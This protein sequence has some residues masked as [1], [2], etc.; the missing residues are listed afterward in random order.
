MAA[1]LKDIRRGTATAGI[2]LGTYLFVLAADGINEGRAERDYASMTP[3]QLKNNITSS[4]PA[5][6]YILASSSLLP[7]SAMK[8]SSGSTRANCAIVC[9]SPL[10]QA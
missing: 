1:R 4:H 2:L 10:I 9:I 7:A 6:Y 5:A 8:R 3:T